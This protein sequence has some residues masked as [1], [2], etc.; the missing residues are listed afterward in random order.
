L[1]TLQGRYGVPHAKSKGLTIA[2]IAHARA[3]LR[4]PACSASRGSQSN[5]LYLHTF[6]SLRDKGSVEMRFRIIACRH[7]VPINV[8]LVMVDG[9]RRA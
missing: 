3:T 7:D 5:P 1:L 6:A 4:D 2:A 9:L 8:R